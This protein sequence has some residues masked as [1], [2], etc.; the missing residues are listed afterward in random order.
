MINS[1]ISKKMS[2]GLASFV[3]LP[4]ILFAQICFAQDA[5]AKD[6]GPANSQ[7]VGTPCRT[8]PWIKNLTA[9]STPPCAAAPTVSSGMSSK[10]AERLAAAASS[11]EEDLKLAEYYKAQAISLEAQGA[12]YDKAAVLYSSG[13]KNLV[14]PTTAAR[15]R[16]YASAL[17]QEAKN[18]RR[19]AED[20][21]EMAQKAAN[22]SVA[23]H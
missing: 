9:P 10:A 16:Y 2:L 20:R 1:V 6:S 14:A 12:Q 7:L 18:D 5:V 8:G 3:L 22:N 19:L 15:Y 23:G 21:T 17:R 13:P 4:A 11:P